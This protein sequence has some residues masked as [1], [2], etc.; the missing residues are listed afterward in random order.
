MK[1]VWEGKWGS[2]MCL[3]VAFVQGLALLPNDSITKLQ[4]KPEI[5]FIKRHTDSLWLIFI[6]RIYCLLLPSNVTNIIFRESKKQYLIQ[7]ES[8]NHA[9]V[10]MSRCIVLVD[11]DVWPWQVWVW[12]DNEAVVC[13]L[14]IF[15]LVWIWEDGGGQRITLPNF[16]MFWLANL[17]LQYQ[18][19]S[20]IKALLSWPRFEF[21]PPSS[22]CTSFKGLILGLGV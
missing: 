20:C 19:S 13:C 7:S 16:S 1:L 4:I 17:T 15:G 3:T 18:M 21:H 22:G 12:W 9:V 2:K 14:L 11:V 8:S 6:K 10:A 5:S